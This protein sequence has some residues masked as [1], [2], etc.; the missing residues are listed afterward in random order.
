MKTSDFD[1]VLPSELI[2]QEP[3][4]PRDSSRLLVVDRAQGSLSHKTFRQLPDYLTVADCLVVNE[5]RVMPAR[6]LGRKAD[7][8]GS[9]E[10]LLVEPL[11]DGDWN[12]LVKPSRRLP[13]GTRVV[14][15]SP[16]LTATVKGSMPDGRRR[17]SLR[18]DGDFKE[19]LSEVGLVPL[20]PY[21]TKVLE[22]SDRYQT[23]Y[24]SREGSVAA[25]TAGLHFTPD[26]IESIWDRGVEF[27]AVDLTVGPGTFQPIRTDEVEAHKL[28]SER[29]EV[30]PEAAAAINRRRGKGGRVIAVGTTSARVLESMT[31]DDGMIRSGTGATDL[32][33]Y[34]GYRFKAV[35]ALVT[36]F[37][38][39]R[40][41]LLMLVCAFAGRE[42][43]MKAYRE[44]IAERYRFYSFGDAMLI[45]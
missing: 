45:L 11:P 6:L 1:Y 42:L 2:A 38:L 9:V 44:A 36:N 43:I 17:V 25:P 26:L 5:T 41:T 4:E 14:F 35:D 13:D 15:S 34:P 27:A 37:H 31:G 23:V 10:I 18:F 33:I 28:H 32:Y 12:A 20:P 3:V 30:T 29:F 8:G 39:P 16:R 22:N 21:I 7:T 19:A 40:S 24:A